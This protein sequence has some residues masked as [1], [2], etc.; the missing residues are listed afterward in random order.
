MVN[1]GT[2]FREAS[3]GEQVYSRWLSIEQ[4]PFDP[5]VPKVTFWPKV[6]TGVLQCGK[7]VLT[8]DRTGVMITNPQLYP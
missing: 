2:G 6:S 4:G 8:E 5:R 7:E 3:T 1:I